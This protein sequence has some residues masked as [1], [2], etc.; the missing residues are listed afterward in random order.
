MEPC[1][2]GDRIMIEMREF[3]LCIKKA[4]A[5]D[6]LRNQEHMSKA[7]GKIDV[8]A[9]KVKNLVDNTTE[10]IQGCKDSRTEIHGRINNL[11]KT[12]VGFLITIIGGFIALFVKN[13]GGH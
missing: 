12:G 6:R 5:E 1:K 7:V 11:W 4:I 3:M 9:E 13:H 8:M 2:Q 10:D